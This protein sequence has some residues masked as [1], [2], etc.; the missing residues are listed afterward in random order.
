MLQRGKSIGNLS[1][2]NSSDPTY[3]NQYQSGHPKYQSTSKLPYV[4]SARFNEDGQSEYSKM[5]K[6][7]NRSQVRKHSGPKNFVNHNHNT[8]KK[9]KFD[10]SHLSQMSNRGE[11]LKRMLIDTIKLMDEKEVEDMQSAIRSVKGGPKS[12]KVKVFP[13]VIL[14]G[15]VNFL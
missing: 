7:S 10:G 8:I 5:G 6:R 11:E 15:Y 4:K 9:P 2:K 13:F 3:M 1:R 14:F 12:Y